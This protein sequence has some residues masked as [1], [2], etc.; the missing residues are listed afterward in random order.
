MLAVNWFAKFVQ[1][2]LKMKNQT[3][4]IMKRSANK[5]SEFRQML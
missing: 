2:T 5:Y 4:C 3:T 1:S